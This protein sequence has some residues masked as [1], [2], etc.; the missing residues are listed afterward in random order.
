MVAAS[1]AS[2]S[3]GRRSTSKPGA[4]RN[5]SIPRSDRGAETRTFHMGRLHPQHGLSRADAR[6]RLDGVAQVR[7]RELDGGEGGQDVEVARPT[8]VRDAE[9]LALEAVL[10]AGDRDPPALTHVLDER[11]AVHARGDPD[12]RASLGGSVR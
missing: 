11:A 5:F 6:A 9:D 8:E 7:E 2:E 3:P 10:T 12:R 1:S 4:P